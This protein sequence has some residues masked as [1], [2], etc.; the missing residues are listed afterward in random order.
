MRC[1]NGEWQGPFPNCIRTSTTPPLPL[2]VRSG[3]KCDQIPDIANAIIKDSGNYFDPTRNSKV[4]AVVR[5]QCQ[6]G[7]QFV[8]GSPSEIVCLSDNQWSSLPSC[9]NI[10]N[11]LAIFSPCKSP[12]PINNAVPSRFID[13]NSFQYSCINGYSVTRGSSN[14]VITC[15]TNQRQWSSTSLV[16]S[17][18]RCGQALEIA[19]AILTTSSFGNSE[20]SIGDKAFYRCASGY[21]LQDQRV[22]SITCQSDGSWSTAPYCVSDAQFETGTRSSFYLSASGC[23]P[24]PSIDHG[25]V[26][27]RSNASNTMGIDWAEYR[28]FNGFVSSGFTRIVCIDGIWTDPPRCL[29]ASSSTCDNPPELSNG[30]II[31][32]S[33]PTASSVL[34]NWVIYACDYGFVISGN[35]KLLC[36]NQLW[37]DMPTC[38][39]DKSE[40]IQ[41]SI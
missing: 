26:V 6:L 22:D 32:K 39:P 17:P 30:Y 37:G 31:E 38:V 5:F 16:C 18:S 8:D 7:F 11:R 10:S 3:A 21:S 41:P 28:C 19:N 23:G 12:P 9:F 35:A 13:S 29:A 1:V 27:S 2:A 20:A 34:Q 36:I 14:V 24:V 15:Q 4:G 25:S 33:T 40:F